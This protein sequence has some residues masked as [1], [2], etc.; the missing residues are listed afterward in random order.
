MAD[1]T[2]TGLNDLNPSTNTYVP[3]SNGTTTG[4]A[5]YNPV[6]VGGI[7]MWSGAVANIPTG[8]ALCNG[9]VVNGNTTPN[10]LDRFIIGAGSAYNPGNTGGSSTTTPAGTIGNTAIT[11]AGTVGDTTLTTAQI[12][13]HNHTSPNNTSGS[14]TA[15]Y[16][17]TRTGGF[18]DRVY[19]SGSETITSSTGSGGSHNHAFTGTSQSHNHTFTG[20]SQANLPPYYALAYIMRVY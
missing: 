2:I 13:S 5:L 6:P 12:P 20:T 1:T 15:G 7:I 14:F 16:G 3:I 19:V 10:L 17:L 8:W 4:K 18:L 9:Q 11:P